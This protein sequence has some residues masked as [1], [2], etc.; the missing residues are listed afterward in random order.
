VMTSKIC[1]SGMDPSGIEQ[2]PSAGR[3]TA[4]HREGTI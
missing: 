1:P 2:R 4:S 3:G